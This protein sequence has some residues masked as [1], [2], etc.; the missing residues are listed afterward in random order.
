[1]GLVKVINNQV[2]PLCNLYRHYF[3]STKRTLYEKAAC[4]IRSTR[5]T[6]YETGHLFYLSTQQ[7]V[8]SLKE[9]VLEGLGIGANR[10][11]ESN[12]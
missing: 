4:V 9:V 7:S 11:D 10:N 6:L 8:Y 12:F 2:M 3:R 5:R 1:M